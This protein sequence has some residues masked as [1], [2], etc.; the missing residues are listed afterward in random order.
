MYTMCYIVL[1]ILLITFSISMYT[2]CYIMLV[3][4]FEPKGGRFKNSLLSV[5]VVGV[6]GGVLSPTYPILYIYI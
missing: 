4:R 1:V 6:G 5:V 2:M 3:Q